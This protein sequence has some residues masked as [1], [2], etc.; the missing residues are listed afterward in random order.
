MAGGPDDGPGERQRSY[1]RK[2]HKTLKNIEKPP[3]A[4]GG[5]G[6]LPRARLW[7]RCPLDGARRLSDSTVARDQLCDRPSSS[8][9]KRKA[10]LAFLGRRSVFVPFDLRVPAPSVSK[11]LLGVEEPMKRVSEAVAG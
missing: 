5:S 3:V 8:G 11:T 6:V 9:F 4:R 7:W 1:R 2:S 10:V